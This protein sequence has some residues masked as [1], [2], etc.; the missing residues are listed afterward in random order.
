MLSRMHAY[1]NI[2]KVRI[3]DD[4]NIIAGVSQPALCVFAVHTWIAAFQI[5]GSEFRQKFAAWVFF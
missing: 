1:D 5:S 2:D 4:L 3:Q